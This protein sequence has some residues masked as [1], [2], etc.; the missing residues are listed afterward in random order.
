V[1]VQLPNVDLARVA[2]WCD[3]K[4]PAFVRNQ[5]RI[6]YQVRAA[7]VTLVER[8]VPWNAMN[9]PYG[10]EWTSRSV[11]Q[12]RFTHGELQLWWPDRN[13]RWHPTEDVPASAS[14]VSLLAALDDPQRA[15]LG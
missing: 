3:E 9:T 11:A 10:N 12:L 6:E 13:T 1:A 5:V 7:T 15:L 14:V 4:V 2:R 8:R